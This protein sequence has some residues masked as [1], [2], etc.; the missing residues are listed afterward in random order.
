[1]PFLDSFIARK[2]NSI[3]H[4]GNKIM[5]TSATEN[6]KAEL[7]IE[8]I[9][10]IGIEALFI[11]PA[12]PSNSAHKKYIMPLKIVKAKIIKHQHGI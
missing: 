3:V 1:M 6:G 12:K 9:A 7:K 5:K 11:N 2:T 4:I 8:V 10:R